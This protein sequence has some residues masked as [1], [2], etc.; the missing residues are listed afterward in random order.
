VP[1]SGIL[2]KLP[3]HPTG[4]GREDGRRGN[5][6]AAGKEV[7]KLR[8]EGNNSSNAKMGGGQMAYNLQ[9]IITIY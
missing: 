9:L 4:R 1:T 3:N 6:R 8:G 7:A 2:R 5:E